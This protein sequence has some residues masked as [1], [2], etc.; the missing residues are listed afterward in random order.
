MTR[1]LAVVVVIAAGCH[2]RPPEDETDAGAP[3][4]EVDAFVVE[5][6][7]RVSDYGE[8]PPALD[9]EAC[10]VCLEPHARALVPYTL[11][12]GQGW[13]TAAVPG[14]LIVAVHATGMPVSFVTTGGLVVSLPERPWAEH[15]DPFPYYLGVP[16][17]AAVPGTNR[18]WI[19]VRWRRHPWRGEGESFTDLVLYEYGE[20][21]W[22]RLASA[23]HEREIG[24]VSAMPSGELIGW[25]RNNSVGGAIYLR[26]RAMDD[27]TVD[28]LER[29]EADDP[30]LFHSSAIWWSLPLETGDMAL[31]V[32]MNPPGMAGNVEE[33]WLLVV[34]AELQ[35]VRPPRRMGAAYDDPAY[36]VDPDVMIPLN[37]RFYSAY[38]RP[39]GIGVVLMAGTRVDS[40]AMRMAELWLQRILP[41]GELAYPIPGVP[42]NPTDYL[43][44]EDVDSPGFM[45]PFAV[46]F[47]LGFD[48]VVWDEVEY[49]DN[50]GSVRVQVIDDDGDR[51]FPEARDMGHNH[52]VALRLWAQLGDVAGPYLGR[53]E[54]LH[55]TGTERKYSV[56]RYG[57]DV[58]WAWPDRVYVQQCEPRHAEPGLMVVAAH[59]GEGVWVLWDDLEW[60]ING[61]SVGLAKVALVRDDGTFA[62]GI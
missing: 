21:G 40:G 26:A 27:G 19:A 45:L 32:E 25:A 61:A 23:G 41:D 16:Q 10:G 18:V 22:R 17:V 60:D 36:E 51:R 33:A 54:F 9:L 58:E 2:D 37:P 47:G 62:W 13:S 44:R 34:D 11:S 28:V 1:W 31:L 7:L 42:V 3:D 39:D 50:D 35:L 24:M 5:P 49:G 15:P 8:P 30:A 48:G 20:D 55:E 4:A 29:T 53:A 14:G 38:Q 52:E 56:V 46:P 57:P 59:G 43:R 6:C 12:S